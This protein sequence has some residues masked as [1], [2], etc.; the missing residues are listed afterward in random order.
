MNATRTFRWIWRINAIVIFLVA[1]AAL[2]G[3]GSLL[4]GELTNNRRRAAE[5]KAAPVVKQADA[6][7]NLRLGPP[8]AIPG[9][10]MLRADLHVAGE[11]TSSFSGSYNR[12]EV[13]N[14]LFIDSLSGESRWL[15]PSHRRVMVDTDTV[16]VPADTTRDRAPMAS[17]TLVKDSP[18]GD[19]GDLIL[20]DATGRKTVLLASAVR[21]IHNTTATG[22]AELVV[23]FERAGKY[24]LARIDTP[25]LTKASELELHLPQLQ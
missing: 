5:A 19:T 9:T 10:R 13:H 16:Y 2:C 14:V 20:F 17:V 1:V 23:V 25:T 8:T 4:L 15:L 3:I 21:R 6:G 7:D 24:V 22:P 11:R 18:D 12:N